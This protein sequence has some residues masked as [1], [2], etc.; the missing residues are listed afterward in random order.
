M[1]AGTNSELRGLHLP[2]PPDLIDPWALGVLVAAAL[3]LLIALVLAGR[4]A[5][6]WWR[7]RPVR[8]ALAE[9]GALERALAVD[10]D[11][12]RILFRLNAC[13][14]RLV[15]S[16]RPETSPGSLHGKCWREVLEALDGVHSASG[17]PVAPWS[18]LSEDP[19]RPRPEL[20]PDDLC[21]LIQGA[22]RLVRQAR[23]GR[24]RSRPRPEPPPGKRPGTRPSPRHGSPTLP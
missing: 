9:L 3:S 20:H 22:Q 17:D 8:V 5:C 1:N 7:A 12:R 24:A 15:R 23:H 2:P 6:H 21:S 4:A 13:L 19:Y 18:L 11:P 10:P 14:K 16:T